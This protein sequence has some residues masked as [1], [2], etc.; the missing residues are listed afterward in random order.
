MNDQVEPD[1][2]PYLAVWDPAVFPDKADWHAAR[3]HFAP[4]RREEPGAIAWLGRA[5]PG[6]RPTAGDEEND[7]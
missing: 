3:F 6:R 7:R 4:H 2:P 5:I 1:F